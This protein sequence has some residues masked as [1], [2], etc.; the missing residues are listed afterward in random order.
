MAKLVLNRLGKHWKPIVISI[1]IV[2][3][4]IMLLGYYLDDT[5]SWRPPRDQDPTNRIPPGEPTD[6]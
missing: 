2:M 4:I 5:K 3:G 1:L 6:R